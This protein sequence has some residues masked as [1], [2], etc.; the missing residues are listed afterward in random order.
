MLPKLERRAERMSERENRRQRERV[1]ELEMEGRGEAKS[2]VMKKAEGNAKKGGE[3]RRVAR[4]EELRK[5]RVPIFFSL[6]AGARKR[7]F[8]QRM[9]AGRDAAGRRTA[10]CPT[11]DVHSESVACVRVSE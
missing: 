11:A 5:Q 3:K 8:T 4:M 1:S 9:S 7:S 2:G 10:A 6:P